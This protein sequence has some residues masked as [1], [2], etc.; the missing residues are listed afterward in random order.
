M[1]V[2]SWIRSNWLIIILGIVIIVLLGKETSPLVKLRSQSMENAGISLSYPSGDVAI[3][4]G[5]YG[6]VVRKVPPAESS[7][8]MVIQDTNMSMLVKDVSESIKGIEKIAID[9]S[10]FMVDRSLTKPEGAASG[11]ISLRVP[12]EKR[13]DALDKIRTIGVRVISENVFGNDVTDQYVDAEARIANLV[14]IKAKMEV[15]LDQAVKVQDLME[16]QMQIN[17]IQEQIDGLKGQQKYLEQTAKLTRISVSLSTDELALPYAPD[18]AWR[19]MV[20]FK[21]AVR[22]MIGAMRSVADVIIWMVVYLPIVIII[23]GLALMGRFVYRKL[24]IR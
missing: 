13:E 17:N 9:M 20:V 3:S 18:S 2:F 6:G 23:L 5:K 21:A 15:I 10:G 14:K 4:N 1:N 16:V 7:Q 24:S 22:S 12:T 11:H 19:P 8:R